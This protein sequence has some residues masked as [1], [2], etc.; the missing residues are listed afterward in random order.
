MYQIRGPQDAELHLCGIGIRIG[1][2][3]R[4]LCKA[5]L[6]CGEGT[7]LTVGAVLSAKL[8]A[9]LCGTEDC[10]NQP[11]ELYGEVTMEERRITLPLGNFKVTECT[12]GEERT[13]LTAYDATYYALSGD[14]VPDT[15]APP[16]TALAVLR[17][18]AAQCGLVLADTT[19]LTDQ[20]VSGT[21][22]GYKCRDMVGYMA[23]LLGCNA[24]IEREGK[25]ALR[26]FVPGDSI[27]P[28]DYYSGGLKLEG[29]Q[30][31]AGL[32]MT[33]KVTVSTTSEDGIVT[34][35]EQTTVYSAGTGTGLV[36]E[37]DNP[38]ATQPIVDAVWAKI[39]GLGTFRTGSCSYFGGL[40]TEPG[41]LLTVTDLQG[42]T[43][44]LPVMGLTLELD[45]GCKATAEARGESETALSANVQGPVGRLLSKIQADIAEFKEL[46]ADNFTA[47]VAKV[48]QLYADDA[49]VKNL[50][51]QQ[52]RAKSVVIGE[53][54]SSY[55]RV[56]KA[57][58][59]IQSGVAPS[60]GPGMN[61]LIWTTVMPSGA[62]TPDARMSLMGVG[63][64]VTRGTYE[65]DAFA[66]DGTIQDDET[67]AYAGF[68]IETWESGVEQ[69]MVVD[70]WNIH[71]DNDCNG[72]CN[73]PDFSSE[74]EGKTVT[75][76]VKEYYGYRGDI[77]SLGDISADGSITAK[78]NIVTESGNISIKKGSFE[79][80]TRLGKYFGINDTEGLAIRMGRTEEEYGVTPAYYGV[81][82]C[83]VKG[84]GEFLG[85]VIALGI[86][87]VLS[88][89]T[90]TYRN[91]VTGFL[92]N[93][94]NLIV[95][96]VPL[97]RPLAAGAAVTCT[98]L[99]VIV[100][101][102]DGGYPYARSGSNGATYTQ[103]GNNYA[104]IWSNGGTVRNNEVTSVQCINRTDSIRVQVEFTYA[105]AKTSGN[106]AAVT[107]VVPVG[108]D[109]DATFEI[110]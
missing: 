67:R 58:V 22:T 14:Y 76:T 55:T 1:Q 2:Q 108:L 81:T 65:G 24:L 100:R 29:E 7:Q 78:G 71:P 99:G 94:T 62:D 9:E 101:H 43:S 57:V 48:N 69:Y 8:T 105:L 38:F 23:A 10:T 70:G 11:A 27:T 31:L 103:L 30:T 59:T 20:T 87:M 41:D 104:Q 12:A 17:D 86:P 97:S 53:T 5:K 49:W 44:V 51:A 56:F 37:V 84:N 110:S 92:A 98:S 34:E 32:R 28:D 80:V 93:G 96:S 50:F 79:L 18:V 54:E 39:G 88:N 68:Q 85:N 102:P 75:V 90:F 4:M 63:V 19:G 3:E 52:I 61:D 72:Y 106:T 95:F 46:T 107:N 13:T 83:F 15:E 36:I 73:L 60:P 89:T 74:Y 6:S 25:L 35:E 82:G 45:G 40:D 109:I 26:W 77:T 91:W 66:I 64:T 16:A 42:V 33:K 47:A 21:L